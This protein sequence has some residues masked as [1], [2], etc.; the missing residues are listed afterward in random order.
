MREHKFIEHV[1]ARKE[2]WG[3]IRPGRGVAPVGR[4]DL[5]LRIL[6]RR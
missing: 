3:K 6:I 4:W 1:T 5:L 2:L